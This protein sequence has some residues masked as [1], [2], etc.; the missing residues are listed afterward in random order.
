MRK[1]YG[2]PNAEPPSAMVSAGRGLMDVWEPIKQSYLNLS[3]P[4]QA[5]IYRQQRS[6]DEKLYDRGLL[7]GNP[8][9]SQPIEAGTLPNGK[10]L[11]FK[12][13]P[14]DNDVWRM[15]GRTAPAGFLA[16]SGGPAEVAMGAMLSQNVMDAIG[17]AQR[18]FGVAPWLEL[19]PLFK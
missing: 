9:W 17:D 3:D 8:Q 1:R 18:R 2:I 16:L 4:A 14:K 11:R 5:A 12:Q 7:A 19:P 15:I 6:E 13:S 10:P